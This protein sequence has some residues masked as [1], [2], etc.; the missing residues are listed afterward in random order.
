MARSRELSRKMGY[1]N[2]PKIGNEYGNFYRIQ[3]GNFCHNNGASTRP[4]GRVCANF[5]K[6]DI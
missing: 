1:W 6:T 3:Y 4:S 5:F 2:N